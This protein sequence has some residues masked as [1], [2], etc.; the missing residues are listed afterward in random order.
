[1]RYVTL[2]DLR[3]VLNDML[4]NKVSL[5]EG[6]H[7]LEDELKANPALPDYLDQMVFDTLDDL[8]ESN[9]FGSDRATTPLMPRPILPSRIPSDSEK[10]IKMK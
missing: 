2:S 7:A 10:T 1:M 5:V 3:Q 9:T 8:I 4:E 6:R